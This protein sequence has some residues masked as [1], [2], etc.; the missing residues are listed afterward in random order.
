MLRLPKHTGLLLVRG[1]QGFTVIEMLVSGIILSIVV[2][3]CFFSMALYLNEWEHN[4][5]GDTEPVEAYRQQRLVT[6]AVESAWEYYVTDRANER[7]DQY[8]HYFK[9]SDTAVAFVTTC[10]VFLDQEVAAARLRLVNGTDQNVQQLVYEEATLN[11]TYIRYHDDPLDYPFSLALDLPGKYFRMKYYGFQELRFLPELEDFEEI[12]AW[13]ET[14]DSKERGVMPEIIAIEDTRG[15]RGV[16]RQFR[17]QA[18]NRGKSG[19]FVD[20]F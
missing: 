6:S 8:Y 17:I 9:G 13:H 20:V 5:L 10:P 19:F 16:I 12:L 1:N 11:T 14:Y 3:L 2:G 4:R 18:R 7:M 15:E